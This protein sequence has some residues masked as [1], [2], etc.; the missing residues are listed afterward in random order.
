[1]ENLSAIQLAAD[2]R[3][4]LETEAQ[5]H[6]LSQDQDAPKKGQPRLRYRRRNR[7]GTAPRPTQT[8]G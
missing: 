1:M 2:R 8:E 4:S 6:R 3:A 5:Q 7:P